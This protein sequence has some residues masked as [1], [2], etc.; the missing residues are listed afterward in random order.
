MSIHKASKYYSAVPLINGNNVRAVASQGQ[1]LED[2][3]R[4]STHLQSRLVYDGRNFAY[5]GTQGWSVE[6]PSGRDDAHHLLNKSTEVGPN[7][8]PRN[9]SSRIPQTPMPDPWKASSEMLPL[10]V[11]RTPPNVPRHGPWPAL[12]DPAGT[13]L[14]GPR[15]A[16]ATFF[17]RS[18]RTRN[19]KIVEDRR[20]V[21]HGLIRPL[22]LLSAKY[23]QMSLT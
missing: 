7:P 15:G 5:P 17:D 13:Y 2:Q 1:H 10:L 22:T 3:G 16:S 6:D 18:R 21:L 14:G 19:M 23:Y 11:D 9:G 20:W 12:N 4:T 8:D